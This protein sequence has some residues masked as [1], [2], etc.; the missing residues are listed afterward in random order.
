M[1]E[2]KVECPSCGCEVPVTKVLQGQLESEI[3]RE[4]QAGL[5]NQRKQLEEREACLLAAQEELKSSN[6]KL[7]QRVNEAL[8]KER[9]KLSEQMLAKARETVQVEL[10]DRDEELSQLKK[11]I[12]D[13]ETAELDLR[14]RERELKEQ[15]ER[16][17]IEVERKMEDERAKVRTEA[18]RQA[19]ERYELKNAEK[20]KTIS[21]MR[22][23]IDELRRKSEQTSQ[24]LQGEVQ[25]LALE[26]RLRNA[27]PWTR[28]ILLGR[29]V[30]ALRLG[31]P[32]AIP[33]VSLPERSSGSRSEPR[34][35]MMP[36]CRKFVTISARPTP[37]SP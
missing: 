15:A 10:T 17:E 7:Q 33:S 37:I 4:M 3:R 22:K 28:S 12:K 1:N 14:R 35:G 25:E 16:F 13:S 27:F 32:S 6:E 21:D 2:M 34:T 31:R 18:M 9:K 30:T 8:E 24:Q 20:D 11:R 29:A 19:D 26:E 5:A 23:K 36:G